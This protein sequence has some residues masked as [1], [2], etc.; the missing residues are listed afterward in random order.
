[1][2][3]SRNGLLKR[4]I[5][6]ELQVGLAATLHVGMPGLLSCKR[7]WQWGR[8]K[9]L[10]TMTKKCAW[11]ISDL[12]MT[13]LSVFSMLLIVHTTAYGPAGVAHSLAVCIKTKHSRP[14]YKPQYDS[15]LSR[16]LDNH[17][18]FV[19]MVH[20]LGGDPTRQTSYMLRLRVARL[21]ETKPRSLR[22]AAGRLGI[23]RKSM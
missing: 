2:S 11:R 16:V 7:R 22:D 9:G 3:F 10:D 21:W 8:Q 13:I 4:G 1:M 20:V 23:G 6:P 17:C 19:A 5:W 18:A 15:A 14:I 12:L